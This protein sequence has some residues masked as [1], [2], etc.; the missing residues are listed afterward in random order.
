MVTCVAARTVLPISRT[1][2]IAPKTPY[3]SGPRMRATTSICSIA[4]TWEM[5][6]PTPDDRRPLDRDPLGGDRLALG[7][8]THL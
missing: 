3:C 8:R 6:R 2:A 7:R 5:A 4:M 1:T